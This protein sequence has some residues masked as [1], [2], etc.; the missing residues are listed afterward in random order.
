VKIAVG[1]TVEQHTELEQPFGDCRS[2]LHH[3]LQQ[4]MVILHMPALQGVDEVGHGGIFRRHRDLHAPLRHHAVGIAE[5]QFRSQHDL[6]A[7]P[8]RM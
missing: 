1:L 4:G 6:R 5:S 7:C 2:I 8:V 3:D